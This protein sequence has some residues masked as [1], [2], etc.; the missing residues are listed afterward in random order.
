[1]SDEESL[2]LQRLYAER[3]GQPVVVKNSLDM[4]LVLIP[5]GEFG[6]SATYTVTLSKPYRIGT[7]EVTSGQFNQFV[8]A[9]GYRTDAE[10][11]RIQNA[12]YLPL[13]QRPANAKPPYHRLNPGWGE[14]SDDQPIVYVTWNDAA[15]FLKWLSEREGRTY[16]LP[17]YAEW[18]WACRAGTATRFYWGNDVLETRKHA[19]MRWSN[20]DR[21]Q[22]VGLLAPNR[23][24]L[25]DT[26]G[27]VSE[28][29]Q[30][31]E[32]MPMPA[33][34]AIDPMGP[35]NGTHRI[36]CGGSYISLADFG[37]DIL[38]AAA[39]QT[40]FVDSTRGFRVVLEP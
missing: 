11:K 4:D 36:A 35:E 24:G 16:R 14:Y 9:T 32:S 3:L 38:P 5:P 20:V 8:A 29:V 2:R 26:L 30:D 19:W 37:R 25:F 31:Y 39:C 17:T 23:W 10:A 33:G 27:N 40:N 1:M 15:A 18:V 21:P 12:T 28:M 13:S 7:Q 34:R 6:M 22:P